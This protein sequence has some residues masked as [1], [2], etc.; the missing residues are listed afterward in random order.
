LK[1]ITSIVGITKAIA[2]YYARHRFATILRRHGAPIEFTGEALGHKNTKTTAGYPDSFGDH[3][4]K[5]WASVLTNFIGN[6]VKR[7]KAI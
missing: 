5:E 1:K 7:K 2:T 4:K 3:A 6:K